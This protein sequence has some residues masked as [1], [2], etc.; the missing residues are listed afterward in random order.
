MR[1]DIR[2]IYSKSLKKHVLHE[3][4]FGV[5]IVLVPA[6]WHKQNHC[7]TRVCF[8]R[9]KPNLDLKIV[10]LLVLLL[11]LQTALLLKLFSN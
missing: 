2:Q 8:L 10:L 1:R 9:M 4:F 6:N 5:A 11:G 3:A 7:E